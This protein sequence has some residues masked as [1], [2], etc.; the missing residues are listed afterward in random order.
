MSNANKIDLD[1]IITKFRNIKKKL[2]KI[3]E[4]EL[5]QKEKNLLAD[6]IQKCDMAIRKLE[7]ADLQNLADEFKAREP[8]LRKAVVKLEDDMKELDDAVAIIDTVS[9]GLE[10]AVEIAKLIK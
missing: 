1:S 8:E 2:L 3:D 7:K 9:T 10:V 4:E 6:W 5:N